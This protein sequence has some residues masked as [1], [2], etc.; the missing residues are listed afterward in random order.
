MISTSTIDVDA[1]AENSN[2]SSHNPISFYKKSNSINKVKSFL[3]FSGSHDD[4]YSY[5]RSQLNIYKQIL[6]RLRSD[7]CPNAI[8]YITNIYD[9]VSDVKKNGDWVSINLKIN[10][11]CAFIINTHKNKFQLANT[12]KLRFNEKQ[13]AKQILFIYDETKNNKIADEFIHKF[14]KKNL[15]MFSFGDILVSALAL[16]FNFI[17]EK[18]YTDNKRYSIIFDQLLSEFGNDRHN[19][20]N[21]LLDCLVKISYFDSMKLLIGDKLYGYNKLDPG[22]T[23]F[24]FDVLRKYHHDNGL[25]KTFPLV[26]MDGNKLYDFIGK[27]D[28]I[29]SF[30]NPLNYSIIIKDNNIIIKHD[31]VDHCIV[32][33]LICEA[34]SIDN[35]I[36]E[37]NG[38]KK[39][40]QTKE[41]KDILKIFFGQN[42]SNK[43]LK[44]LIKNKITF[45]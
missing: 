38:N 26:A 28:N 5:I 32:S 24:C 20:I 1:T 3:L 6:E 40:L 41:T 22:I 16:Q 17:V 37:R 31:K 43:K 7:L 45:E 12:M 15:K 23:H 36:S 33:S 27:F 19:A 44:Y 18:A 21:E 11:F 10:P 14:N 4:Y 30:K 25:I 2:A 39:L 8:D 35:F 13:K 29:E 34:T 42:L 9:I